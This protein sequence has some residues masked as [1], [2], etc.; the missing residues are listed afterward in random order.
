[1]LSHS[2]PRVFV[3]VTLVWALLVG[4][5]AEAQSPSERLA[6]AARSSERPKECRKGGNR[7]G[8]A[9]YTIWDHARS[10][11]LSR[12]CDILGQSL[13]LLDRSP[14]E[15]REKSVLANDVLSGFAS[16]FVLSARASVRLG[17]Y[18][19]A[20]SDFQK[21]RVIDPSGADEPGVLR[22]LALAQRGAGA[23]S[24]AI[25][26]YRVLV[27]RIDL[28]PDPEDRTLVLLEYAS[29]AMHLAAGGGVD[30]GEV[31]MRS[32][33]GTGDG[34]RIE[35]G[36]D[37]AVAALTV[38][39]SMPTSRSSP[40]V[41]GLL[42]LALSRSSLPDQS[43]AVIEALRRANQLELL[44]SI[45]PNSLSFLVDRNEWTAVLALAWERDDRRR[46]LLLW[47]QFVGS[48]PLSG[49]AAHAQSRILWLRGQP[50]ISV[51]ST[52]GMSHGGV[53]RRVDEL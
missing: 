18:R 32:E 6:V 35:V 5:S 52:S 38:A 39:R 26:T 9:R 47:K 46:A 49:N 4:A 36:I 31:G 13:A 7:R 8:G 11:Y 30:R 14:G 10:P 41:L 25:L 23:L 34:G 53:R 12:Y 42:A 2:S 15:A 37:E 45:N 51:R 27:P 48:E 29:L 40:M 28:L 21:A 16:P 19:R 17:D 1:M 33:G 3:A 50:A 44:D 24:D 43:E 22:D 20:L